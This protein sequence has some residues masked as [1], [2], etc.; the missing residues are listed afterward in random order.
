MLA[1]GVSLSSYVVTHA[2]RVVS[3]I[4]HVVGSMAG[5][6][7]T[8]AHVAAFTSGNVDSIACNAGNIGDNVENTSCVVGN[9][10]H[11]VGHKGSTAGNRTDNVRQWV[12]GVGQNADSS[13]KLECNVGSADWQSGN[14][15]AVNSNIFYVFFRLRLPS[16]VDGGWMRALPF[17]A[18]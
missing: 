1:D 9:M 7:G 13:G 15:A 11:V 3:P 6:V 18:S 5:V 16:V 10:P 4:S 12:Y 14:V 8:I 2:S 17:K